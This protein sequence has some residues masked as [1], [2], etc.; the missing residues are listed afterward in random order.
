MRE[1][2]IKQALSERYGDGS[3]PGPIAEATT[4]LLRLLHAELALV[5]GAQASAALVVHAVHRTRSKLDWTAPPAA[6]PETLLVALHDDLAARP[7]ADCL[8]A[9]ETLIFA[10]VDHLIS[11]IGEPLTLRMLISAWST[12]GADQSSQE[13]L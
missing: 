10:L 4:T 1:D 6:A 13:N 9:G 8:F 5:V 11:L 7:T 12:H 3:D 2:I